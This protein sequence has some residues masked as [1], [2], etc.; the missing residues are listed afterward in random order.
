MHNKL[1]NKLILSIVICE[2]TRKSTRKRIVVSAN[3]ELFSRDSGILTEI[4]STTKPFAGRFANQRKTLPTSTES[5]LAFVGV[6]LINALSLQCLAVWTCRFAT[7][8]LIAPIAA[9]R[10]RSCQF[11]E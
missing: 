9:R 10:R 6:K 8:V 4:A 3:L 7:H 1:L 11:L 2:S 5:G